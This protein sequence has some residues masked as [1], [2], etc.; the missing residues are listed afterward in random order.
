MVVHQIMIH[1]EEIEII[2]LKNNSL[3]YRNDPIYMNMNKYD[4]PHFVKSLKNNQWKK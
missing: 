1:R 2:H 4:I 3:Y